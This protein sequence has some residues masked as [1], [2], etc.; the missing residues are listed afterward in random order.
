MVDNAGIRL[1]CLIGLGN[2]D[3]VHDSL[4]LAVHP[5]AGE[6]EVGPR[7]FFETQNVL[8]EADRV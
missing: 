5:G 6:R 1:L 8:V 3:D 7:A 4:A 2:I